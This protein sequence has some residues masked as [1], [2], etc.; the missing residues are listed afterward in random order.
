MNFPTDEEIDNLET[1][2]IVVVPMTEDGYLSGRNS[3]LEG[4]KYFLS[5]WFF[6]GKDQDFDL[7]CL[8][9]DSEDNI[10]IDLEPIHN[11]LGNED[12]L[13]FTKILNKIPFKDL[14]NI[15]LRVRIPCD[16]KVQ[17]QAFG[18]GRGL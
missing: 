1:G 2:D 11:W 17:K 8:F 9:I 7:I 6:L 18:V 13:R 5:R 14:E 15:D 16:V 12:K 3:I 4:D 10:Q